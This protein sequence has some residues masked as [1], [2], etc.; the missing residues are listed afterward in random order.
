MTEQKPKE[1]GILSSIFLSYFVL[2]LHALLAVLLGLA[3][4][5]FRGVVEYMGWIL[6]GGLLLVLVS[7][8]YFYRLI[9]KNN[10]K[11]RDVINDP[12]FRDRPLE[13][14]F[15]GGV[16]SFRIGQPQDHRRIIDAGDS[17]P[18]HQLESPEA[19]RLRELERLSRLLEDNRITLDEYDQLKKEIIKEPFPQRHH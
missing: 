15:L 4:V 3:V 6:L 14:S 18:I 8:Y 17:G 10:R 7:C 2:I 5:F 11:L 1:K 9:K 16:A 12:A 13:V 19:L